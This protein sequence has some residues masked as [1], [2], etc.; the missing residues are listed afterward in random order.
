MAITF[1]IVL[2]Q[3][4][5][6]RSFTQTETSFAAMASSPWSGAQ[7]VQLNQGQLWGFSVAYPPM[8]DDQ[9][10]AWSGTLAQLNGRYGTFLFGD[11][12]WKAPRG[13]WA[14]APVVDGP[15]QMGQTLAMRGFTAGAQGLAGDLFQHG[16]GASARL[17]KVTADFTADG[18]G[19]AQVE[20]WPRLRISPGDG[21]SLTLAS[22]KGVF[23]LASPI[24]S[25]SWE[26]FR[27]GF[28]FD[29]IEAL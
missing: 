18:A 20:I 8:S 10:R 13:S 12:R 29:M 21:D 26:P 3:Q 28:S 4:P 15:G 22:P 7:Q 19:E 11:P 17:Y 1:P 5:A 2:P 14:G 23:R 9:A 16:S 25:R 24:V 6:P 27:H